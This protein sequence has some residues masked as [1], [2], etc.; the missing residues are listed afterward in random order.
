MDLS[1]AIEQASAF[2]IPGFLSGDEALTAERRKNEEAI[3]LLTDAWMSAPAGSEP[4]SF[5][6]VRN[7]ADRNRAICDS[8]GIERLRNESGTSL[9]RR[10]SDE[11]LIRS[12]AVLQHRPVEEVR[13]SAGPQ[14]RDLNVAYVEA[15]VSGMICGIDLETTDRYPDRGYII[16]VGMEFVKLAPKG[17]AERGYVAY[18]GLPNIYE[19]K[20]VPLSEV[21]HISWGDLAGKL[22]F[23]ENRDLQKA[24]LSSLETF[25]FMAHNAAFEDSWLMLNLDGY[26]EGRK[27]GRIIPIDTRD[28]CRRIDPEY[29][30]LPHD[31]RPATLEN[32]ARRRGTLKK[33]EKERHLGLEDVDLMFR[34][35]EAEFAARNMF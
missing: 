28:I 6:L 12:V 16:N 34:T 5:D 20:G 14:A 23:R 30:T 1:Q 7:L 21:H 19:E 25:P 26:A 11:D 33:D 10:L 2:V 18:C 3:S 4:F 15:P 9:A 29:R 8:F 22:P 32:W 35:V 24:I 27:A 31:S 17:K 13:R